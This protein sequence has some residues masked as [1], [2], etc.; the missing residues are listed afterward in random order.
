MLKEFMGDTRGAA[1]SDSILLVA[2]FGLFLVVLSELA[3][4]GL[5]EL[6]EDLAL[7]IED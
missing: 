5:T 6:M 7:F 4:G 1:L 2:G 3:G